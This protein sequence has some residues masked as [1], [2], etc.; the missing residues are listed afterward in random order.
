[1]ESIT[2]FFRQSKRG[3]D[4]PSLYSRRQNEVCF[5][6]KLPLLYASK[7]NRRLPSAATNP[8]FPVPRPSPLVLEMPPAGEDHGNTVAVA[9]GQGGFVVL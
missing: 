4:R 3:G 9:G 5:S 7:V 6:R 1:V 8:Q 2:R